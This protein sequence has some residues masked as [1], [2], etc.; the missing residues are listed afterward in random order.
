M[1]SYKNRH[2]SK[3]VIPRIIHQIW[4]GNKPIPEAFS[5]FPNTWRNKNKNWDYV[6]WTDENICKLTKLDKTILELLDNYSEKSDYIR[7]CIL[8]EYG[9]IYADVD[10]ECLKS[11][12]SIVKFNDFFIWREKNWYLNAGLFGC[13][14]EN[15]I[16]KEVLSKIPE[17]AIKRKNMD[18]FHK[19]WPAFITKI[20]EASDDHKKIFPYSYFYPFSRFDNISDEDKKRSGAYAIHHNAM[21]WSKLW[22]IKKE[23]VKLIKKI[24]I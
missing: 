16:V 19:I 22:R 12:D 3:M 14:K 18:A 9:G 8:E 23:I 17:A 7:F 15:K 21:S 11:F 10:F 6:L 2:N 5:N 24:W 20:I 1:L 4:I 13:S